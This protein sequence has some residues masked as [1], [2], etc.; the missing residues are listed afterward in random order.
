[1]K[2]AFILIK[3]YFVRNRLAALLSVVSGVALCFLIYLMGG[4]VKDASLS[5]NGIGVIDYDNSI[6]SA[7]FKSYLADELDYELIEHD[8]Y[9]YLTE[10][11][12]DKSISSII[13]I[14][15]GFYDTFASGKDGNIIATYTDDF[16]N[17]AFL[18]AYINSYLSGIRMLSV[19]ATG[20]QNTFNTLLTEYKEMNTSI[21]KA[22]AYELDIEKFS[23]K[24][25]FRN[26]IGFFLQIIFALGMIISFVIIDDRISGIYNR[27][28]ITPVKPVQY[29]AGISVFGFILS[30]IMCAIYCGFIE[31][32]GIDIGFPIYKLFLLMM[33]LS[34]FII[35]FVVDASLLIMSKSGVLSLIMGYSTLGAILGGA[36]FPI[37]FAPESFQS[38][39]K[40]L[41]QFWFMDTVRKLLDN[42]LADVTYN[43]VILCLFSIL[44]FLIG[45]VL[46]SQNYK[47]R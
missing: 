26:T 24:E 28:T 19:G 18:E 7:D 29:I 15:E 45:A 35:C 12:I 14:P 10:L 17:A 21:F 31:V 6:L 23:Q 38:M 43:V 46:F 2:N 47:N 20:E 37:D 1:M 11:L 44:A 39:A 8:S 25:G 22:K 33:L 40:V 41:P 34:F 9:D 13:E 16:E 30:M 27:I 32:V 4:F 5:K 42:P 36:Y 3:S